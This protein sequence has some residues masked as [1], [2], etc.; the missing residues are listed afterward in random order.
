M[1]A[2]RYRDEHN[3]VGYLLKHTGSDDY[4]QIIDFLR[5][6]HIRSPELGPP[7]I[8]ATIDKTPYTITKDL[9]GAHMPLLAPMLVVPAG[10]DGADAVAAV[11][12]AVNEVPPPSLPPVTPPPDVPPTHTYSST[13]GPSTVVQDTPVR[14]PTPSPMREPTTFWKPTPEPP[15]PSPPSPLPC[16]TRQTSFIEDISEDGGGCVSSPKSNEAPPT[17][18]T[19]VAGGA[20]DTVA[21]TNLSLK[22]DRC[23]N[24]VITLENELGVTKKVLGGAV[25]NLVSRVKRLEGILKHRK[26]S[27]V[28]FDSEG[29]EAP[30]KEPEINLDALHELA[31]TS[32]GSDTTVEAAYTIFKASQD[33]YASSDVGHDEDEVPDSTNM[34]FRRT[35]TKRRRLRK[36]FTSSAFK[37]FQENIS[38]VKDTIPTG[39][40]IPADAQTIPA[41]STPI[42]TTGGV[43]AGSS[44]D[45]ASHVA[46]AP[47]LFAILATNKGKDP[48]VDDSIPADLL[49]EQ[50]REL[51][52]KAQDESVA[53]P[54]AQDWLE[55]MAKIATNSALSKQLLGDDVNKDNINERLGML[56]MRKRRE[57]AEQSRVKPMNKTQQ[58]D[59]MR[60][61]VKNQ[62]ASVYNQG[63]TMKQ[64]KALSIAQ[65]KHEFE[66]IQRNLERSNLLNFKRSTFRPK[67]TLEAPTAKRARQGVPQAP[68]ASSHVPAS[69]PVASSIAADVSVSAVSTTTADV[70]PAPT[71]PAESV[72][73]VHANES[74]PDKNQTTSEQVSTEHMSTTVAFTSG[75]S[76]A[77]HSSSRKRRK[78]IA[79]K[80]VTPIVDVVDDA[81]IK[82]DSASESDET[83]D[84]RV[85][86]MF[87]D[88][89]YPLS[90]ATLER[91]LRH[92]LEVPKLLVGG[93]LKMA[94]S[95]F[96]LSRLL[97]SMLNLLF[98]PCSPWLTAKKELT[99]HE[100]T[101]LN[102]KWLVQGGTTLELASPEQTAT[103]SGEVVYMFADVSYLLSVKLMERMLTHKLGID[104]DVV[105]NDMTTIEQL[106][107]FIKN[108]LVAAQVP[109]LSHA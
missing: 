97:Y 23:I 105:G 94:N 89:S 13:P 3:K 9:D 100:G 107:Q 87:F 101:T 26:R 57:L 14:E 50:E 69:V 7:A 88:V 41:G 21:L 36:T 78:Q 63:W 34:P 84:G 40:G 104:K 106:I 79:K 2:L 18:A 92:G 75:V 16:P 53:S 29:V 109:Y 54:A 61:F 33:A 55:L 28:L 24:R 38:A 86:Y 32:L 98:D 42:P 81:L 35:R 49:T 12:A 56:L 46:A 30:T 43:S 48:M 44:M 95:W 66:Y 58:R 70:S 91:M 19:I 90:E 59:F 37:H 68:A 76:H 4:H 1:A 6:S 45:P 73:E 5:A 99:H 71:L 67:P 60:D 96:V 11:A 8:Q 47:S 22:L 93:D 52:Q 85:I 74:R 20:E 103:V 80:K 102:E 83:V 15:R 17:T 27:M 77:T 82:F 51:A 31:S 65:L 39:D 10:G 108:Q 72:A 64:V 62:S 25:L